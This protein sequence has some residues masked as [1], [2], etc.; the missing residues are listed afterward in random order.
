MARLAEPIERGVWVVRRIGGRQR[1]SSGA[2]AMSLYEVVGNGGCHGMWL[3]LL[4]FARVWV[5]RI[6]W[7]WAASP[8]GNME[9]LYIAT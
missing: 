1:G 8:P 7:L 6:R 9:V 4:S 5:S 2:A 3:S